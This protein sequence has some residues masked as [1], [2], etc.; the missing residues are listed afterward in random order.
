MQQDTTNRPF[1]VTAIS[2]LLAIHG[3]VAILAG[4]GVF[5]PYP[6][7]FLGVTLQIIYGVVLFL[8][9]YG[10][11]HFE[12]WAWLTTLA[13]Q[14]FNIV[15]TVL[16]LFEVPSFVGGWILLVMEIA[17]VSYLLHPSVSSRFTPPEAT[18]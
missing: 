12:G 5:G 11:Y 4:I 13:F 3:V 17:I 6:G 18:S 14:V 2:I 15:F 1:G 7:G 16:I 9:A 10:M 8:L